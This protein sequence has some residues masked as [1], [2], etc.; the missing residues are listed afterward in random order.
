[1]LPI[2]MTGGASA[3]DRPPALT[4]LP[5]SHRCQPLPPKETRRDRRELIAHTHGSHRA[6]DITANLLGL[7]N[8]RIWSH[9]GHGNG[10]CVLSLGEAD[11]H[12]RISRWIDAPPVFVFSHS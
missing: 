12:G 9:A 4:P 2:A 6:G 1:M 11:R 5:V 8:G 3:V 7:A 10:L